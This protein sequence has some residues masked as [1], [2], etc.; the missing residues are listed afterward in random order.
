[1]PKRRSTRRNDEPIEFWNSFFFKFSSKIFLGFF[2]VLVFLTLTQCTVKTPESPVWNTT[3]V[4]PVV[5]RTYNMQEII[6]KIDQDEITIDSAGNIAF[7]VS[8]DLDTVSIEDSDLTTDNLS[9]S[10]SEVLGR[11]TVS[12]PVDQIDTV[13]ID[14]LTAG[15]PSVPGFDTL[16]VPANTEFTAN[17]DRSLESFASASITSGSIKIRVSNQLGLTLYDV[18]V[19]VIDA[20][21]SVTIDTGYFINP[22][23][24]NERDSLVLSLAGKTVSDSIRVSVFSHTDAFNDIHVSPNGKAIFT[25]VIFPEDIEVSQALAE[26]PALEDLVFSQRVGLSF[27]AGETIDVAR[28][29]TGTLQLMIAN[30]TPL[31]SD[32]V[33]SVPNLQLDGT[34]LEIRRQVLGGQMALINTDL[35][36]YDLIPDNDSVLI[37]VVAALPGSEGALVFVQETDSIGV[38]AGL[39][40]LSFS[41]VTGAFSSIAA[42]FD[43]IHEELNVPDG[44]DNITLLSAEP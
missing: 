6:E 37:S 7:A 17:S 43:G 44:F 34:P 15:F 36:G 25:E 9:Y 4:M 24:H 3:F 1:M 11:I 31:V 5:N 22:L 14:S 28:L 26:V 19:R 38:D 23:A 40:N 41:S 27:D 10:V 13:S 29:E 30:N 33:I 32:M 42:D 8:Q 16:I 18:V 20:E 39:T 21:N 12:R 2:V 35:A